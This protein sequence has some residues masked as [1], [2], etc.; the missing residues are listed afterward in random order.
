MLNEDRYYDTIYNRKYEP[1]Y[2]K[3]LQYSINGND[4]QKHMPYNISGIRSPDP[5]TIFKK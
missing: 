4:L 1:D 3:F 5:S 2:I